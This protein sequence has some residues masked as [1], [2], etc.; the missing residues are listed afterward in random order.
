MRL[1]QSHGPNPRVVTMYIAEKGISLPRQFVDI[2]AGE[3]RQA[4]FLAKNPAG[5]LPCL[6]LD[7]GSFLS[8]SL[9]ICEYL[10]ELYPSPALIGDTAEQRAQ[11]RSMI[12]SIDQN[13]VVPMT[14][15]F[16][17]SEGLALFKDRLLCVPSA[18]EGNKAYARDG[19]ASIDSRLADG[20]WLC[21]S[22]FS[23][24]DILLFAFVDFG[25]QVGQPVP[26]SLPN[27]K[28]WSE[29]I[30]ARPSAVVSANPSNGV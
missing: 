25:N 4:A 1:Y 11:T 22:R 19:M 3:N 28:A 18:A 7:D 13:V 20:G 16:R 9:A 24:A 6:E 14:N 23:L 15:G 8:E 30:A 17:S 27:L 26:D 29:R 21:G 12:R 5:G 10:E 2:M